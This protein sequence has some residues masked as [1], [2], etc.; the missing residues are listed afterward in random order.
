VIETG[1]QGS[2]QTSLQAQRERWWA[3][4]SRTCGRI[5]GDLRLWQAQSRPSDG[6]EVPDRYPWCEWEVALDAGVIK[7]TP[8][9]PRK[10]PTLPFVPSQQPTLH[11]VRCAD[12]ATK[13]HG[14]DAA[15]KVSDYLA[16][17]TGFLI[18]YDSGEF[19][20]ELSS[21]DRDGHLTQAIADEN[22]SR[23]LKTPEGILALA[24]VAHL[25]LDSGSVLKLTPLADNKWSTTQTNLP[26]APHT[27][28][29]LPDGSIFVVTTQ[30][31]V[32]V[33]SGPRVTVLHHGGWRGLYPNSLVQDRDG[34]FYIG[35]RHFIVRLRPVTAGY[36][37]DWLVPSG[38]HPQTEAQAG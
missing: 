13:P 31:L 11:V 4:Y 10:A 33:D 6:S 17:P 36:H 12:E 14:P 32:R 18:A 9:L 26:G 1:A 27:V 8:A 22:V 21:F 15:L 16:S 2:T 34:T 37:E 24:G 20:G 30:H 38:T 35:I 25:T 7:V 5:G 23:I 28:L 3:D 29:P 19:G